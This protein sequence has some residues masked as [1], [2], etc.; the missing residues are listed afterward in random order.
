MDV[1]S[2]QNLENHGTFD[3]GVPRKTHLG[4]APMVNH[5]EYYKREGGGFPQVRVMVNFVNS[6][7]PVSYLCTKNVSIMH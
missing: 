4:V 1:Q 7:V 5:K 2:G 3:L 6:C